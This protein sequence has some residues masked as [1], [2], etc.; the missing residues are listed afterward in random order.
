MLLHS[1]ITRTWL[2]SLALTSSSSDSRVVQ[3][4]YLLAVYVSSSFLTLI[5][6]FC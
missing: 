1:F 6:A 2:S 3:I 4:S 5:P